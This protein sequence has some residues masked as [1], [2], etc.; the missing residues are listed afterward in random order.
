ML[1]QQQVRGFTFKFLVNAEKKKNKDMHDHLQK[2]RKAFDSSSNLKG[3]S[4]YSFQ[5]HIF[6]HLD[7][8]S[9]QPDPQACMK[10]N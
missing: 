6:Q 9:N 3:Q 1:K 4:S 2:H 8:S 7:V 10:A 5:I